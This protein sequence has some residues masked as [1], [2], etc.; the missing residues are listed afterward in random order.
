VNILKKYNKFPAVIIKNI[1]Y[2]ISYIQKEIS[3]KTKVEDLEKIYFIINNN[4]PLKNE[5]LIE[6][7]LL[8]FNKN[9]NDDFKSFV[10]YL[11][12]NENDSEL[13]EGFSKNKLE[14]DLLKK[15]PKL[16]LK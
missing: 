9:E 16:V 14:E 1:N 12:M 11:L 4:T 6:K 8:T 7:I 5:T 2:L 15:K 10:T 13:L 3:E